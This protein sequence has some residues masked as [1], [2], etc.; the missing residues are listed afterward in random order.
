MRISFAKCLY[1]WRLTRHKNIGLRYRKPR[2]GEREQK[3]W[4]TSG[5]IT[6]G[7]IVPTRRSRSRTALQRRTLPA[8][9]A[10]ALSAASPA[11]TPRHL[12]DNKHLTRYTM[13]IK[14]FVIGILAG[15][16]LT[17]AGILVYGRI[18]KANNPYKERFEFLDHPVSYEGEKDVF[19]HVIQVINDSTALAADGPLAIPG[20]DKPVALLGRDFYDGQ[21][22]HVKYPRRVGTYRYFNKDKEPM[23][24]AVIRVTDEDTEE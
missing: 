5:S 20:Y 4:G 22:I 6:S 16:A 7:S 12:H 19:L 2:S 3:E 13:N 15:I 10:H 24:V 21:N 17:I 8:P 9:E 23:T 11:P 14:S 18:A 1:L